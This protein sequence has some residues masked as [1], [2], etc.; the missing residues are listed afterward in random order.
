MSEQR[1]MATAHKRAIKAEE[2]RYKRLVQA[3]IECG[4]SISRHEKHFER[5]T[6]RATVLQEKLKCLTDTK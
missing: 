5:Y 3:V 1:E 2:M 4:K 6:N